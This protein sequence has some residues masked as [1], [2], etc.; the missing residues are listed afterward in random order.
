M[1]FQLNP[2]PEVYPCTI[3]G[4]N[5][6]EDDKAICCDS[7]NCWVHVSC[8]P[9]VSDADYDKM[10]ESPSD[11]QWFCYMCLTAGSDNYVCDAQLDHLQSKMAIHCVCLNSRSILPKRNDLFAYLSSHK[12][13]I[14][15]I[16]E[17]FLDSTILDAE[18][19]LPSYVVFRRDR[20]R[21]GGGVL[22]MVR[23]DLQVSQR[24]DLDLF[25]DELLW[26]EVVTSLG[27]LLF[28]VYYHPPSQ[29][30]SDLLSLNN[31]LLS[32]AKYPIIL[33]GDFNVPNIDW[34]T[35]FPTT[36]CSASTILC[37]LVHDN[38]LHQM[39]HSPTRQHNILDLVLTNSP[40]IVTNVYLS[41]NLPFTDHDAVE[42]SLSMLVP[43]QSSCRRVLY[44]YKK[45]D[46][47]GLIETLSHVPWNTIETADSIESSW[48]MFKDLF[49]TAVDS[50]VPKLRWKQKKLKH[51]FSY[52]T[53]H[54]IR[55]KR[56]LYLQLKKQF[57]VTLLS[58][59]K[60]LRNKVRYL[61][62]MDTRI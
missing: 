26:L 9:N 50:F 6:L 46:L 59:Y 35:G 53:I 34:S 24:P 42:F 40:D 23:E 45:A 20:T 16:V 8:D 22:L 56:H 18:V 27:P 60:K 43:S 44:N 62:R 1:I 47:S 13:D 41:D 51:W 32:I 31:C 61:T 3:C 4:V 38:H 2:G 19:C 49:L 37:E 11:Q 33:C 39:V 10:L 21:H 30:V 25:C 54:L 58:E 28:G 52:G 36:S 5:V 7:C 14:L 29:S 55:K 17:T 57:S 12:V 15:A 48:S